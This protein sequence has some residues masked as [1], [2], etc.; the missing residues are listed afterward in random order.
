MHDDFIGFFFTEVLP[1]PIL[2]CLYL[3]IFLLTFDYTCFRF[4]IARRGRCMIADDM[5]LGKT[6]QALAIA[7]YYKHNWPLLIVTTSSMRFVVKLIDVRE[8][9]FH[10]FI[11]NSVNT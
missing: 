8:L 9:L 3:S 7:S 11:K 2:N 6:F 10:L 1:E 5:G 4:G